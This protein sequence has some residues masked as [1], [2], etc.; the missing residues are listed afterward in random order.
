M[1]VLD[2]AIDGLPDALIVLDRD[3][4][5]QYSN[6]TAR[7]WF[8][9]M[10]GVHVDD[11]IGKS[12]FDT[13]P[14]LLG[15]RFEQ[16]Y[17]RAM[18]ERRARSFEALHERS[19]GWYNVRV[20]PANDL[21]TIQIRDVTRERAGQEFLVEATRVLMDTL[22][23]TETVRRLARLAV[24]RLADWCVVYVADENGTLKHEAIVHVDGEKVRYAHELSQR[25]PP[26]PQ[27]ASGVYN[28]FRTG[29][30]E[31]VPEITDEALA[32]NIQDPEYL[33]IVRKLGFRS[34]MMVPLIAHG[35]TRG[36]MAF[37]LAETDRRYDRSDVELAETL[38]ARAA[39]SV[40]NARLFDRLQRRQLEE[41]ALRSATEAVSATFSV[42]AVIA[43]IA[44]SA[45]D[46]TS[47]DGSFV[48]RVQSDGREVVV[49]AA[50]GEL[51]PD[52]GTRFPFDGSLA[53]YVLETRQ[54]EMIPVIGQTRK[55]L[56]GLLSP[57]FARASAVVVPL[58]DAGEAIG[59]LILVRN[60]GREA[61]SQDE[62]ERAH[63][64]G[65]L[66]AL[67]FRKVHLIEDTERRR[68]ELEQLM[69]SRVRFM[70]G[71]SHDLKNPI[72]AADGHASLLED[73]LLGELTDKQ[74]SSV[75]RIRE[76][77]KA[78]VQ[79]INDLVE[80]AK[81]EAGQLQVRTQPLD[82]REIVR[83]MVEHYRPAAEQAGLVIRGELEAVEIVPGDADRVRQ[84]LGNLLSNAIKY[85][86]SGT[87]VARTA[88]R[89]SDKDLGEKECVVIDVVDTGIGIPE[90]R[91]HLLFT[92]FERIDPTVKPGAGLGLAI[93]RRVAR[94]IG[95]ELTVRTRR[96]E[97]SAFTL[98][99]P[100][101]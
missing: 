89:R 101:R 68:A 8:R 97:G 88:M 13:A 49:V 6:A 10:I 85:T 4:R 34:T 18:E 67:A 12:I 29:K 51:H 62:V 78:S 41:L 27:S 55:P 61:F 100:A 15:T 20:S 53:Q 1:T 48:E 33:A 70:R 75:R 82:V 94:A 74:L 22:D 60:E 99:L 36:V 57:T 69:E 38:A 17:R 19:N 79:L 52:I 47:A 35:Q 25:Y 77:L 46:A 5:L 95:G 14:S 91:I 32:A 39:I 23:Y 44:H 3:W 31:C 28:V 45:L 26:N 83:E 65:N 98:W 9:D 64:F 42:D 73:G 58:I 54:P 50:A 40:E 80:L 87:I 21:L 11:A 92:E 71:F 2:R 93:S 84:I 63:T 66:A 59:T 72:G 7:Q 90:D 76:G 81:A 43:Q 56:P 86:K 30:S 37:I 24:P 16:E 96:G